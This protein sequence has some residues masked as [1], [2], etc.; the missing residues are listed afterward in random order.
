MNA[1]LN[2]GLVPAIKLIKSINDELPQQKR[3]QGIHIEA[4][5][6]EAARKYSGPNTPKALLIH[7]LGYAAD[8]VLKPVVDLTGQ[9]R[10][11][12]SYL[13]GANSAERRN[14]SQALA[15][16]KRRL[17]AATTVAQWRAVFGE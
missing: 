7:I 4:M 6:V 12:D 14:V 16:M 3:L 8:R 13:G 1:Q 9:S 2:Q 10:T 5:A 17:E 11:V 15:G